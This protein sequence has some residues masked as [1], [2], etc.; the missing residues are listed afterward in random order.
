MRFVA[1]TPLIVLAFAGSSAAQ[2]PPAP[3]DQDPRAGQEAEILVGVHGI[4]GD[5]G[6]VRIAL[7]DGAEGFTDRPWQA[8]VVLPRDGSAEWAVRVPYGTYAL[9]VVHDRDDNGKLNTNLLGMP[10]E[11]YGFSNDAR[12]TFGP[13]SFDDASFEVAESSVRVEVRVR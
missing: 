11:R 7:F 13:P 3:V 4:E 8:A 2:A 12:G 9:G 10:R 1:I 5:E 6:S